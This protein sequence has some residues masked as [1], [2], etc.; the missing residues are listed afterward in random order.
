MLGEL[1]LLICASLP[2]GAGS[3]ESTDLLHE[4]HRFSGELVRAY[5]DARVLWWEQDEAPDDQRLTVHRLNCLNTLCPLI[6]DPRAELSKKPPMLVLFSISSP[7][8][9]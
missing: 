1:A 6:L 4:Y 9:I 5:F 2:E 3:P 8:F 7:L